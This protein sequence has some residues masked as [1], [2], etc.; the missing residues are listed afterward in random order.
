MDMTPLSFVRICLIRAHHYFHF[1]YKVEV[2]IAEGREELGVREALGDPEL[3]KGW[4]RMAGQGVEAGIQAI[5]QAPF[6]VLS[7][8]EILS[9]SHVTNEET[10]S[11]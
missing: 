3:P 2:K 1:F 11:L 8:L 5:D 10:K 6:R 7:V 4:G 9:F